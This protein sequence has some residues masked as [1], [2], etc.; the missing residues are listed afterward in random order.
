MDV[1]T[2]PMAKIHIAGAI[3]ANNGSPPLPSK[4]QRGIGV[5]DRRVKAVKHPIVSSGDMDACTASLTV[6]KT[7]SFIESGYS[8]PES[9]A[10][11]ISVKGT[12]RE[13]LQT[14]YNC[15]AVHS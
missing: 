13:Q 14:P 15:Y 11:T 4:N 2:R 7:P 10:L 3:Q 9:W 6:G 5:M 8:L 12:I 1:A